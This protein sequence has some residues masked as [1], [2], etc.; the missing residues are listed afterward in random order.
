MQAQISRGPS[1][2]LTGGSRLGTG[3]DFPKPPDWS[4]GPDP[5]GTVLNPGSPQ[6]AGVPAANGAADIGAT[7]GAQV[8]DRDIDS[9]GDRA[10]NALFASLPV[11]AKRRAALGDD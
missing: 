1:G 9:E 11:A 7:G 2:G 10:F 4:R 6:A 3:P 8:P 5:A